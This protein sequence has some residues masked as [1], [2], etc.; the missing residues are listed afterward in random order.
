MQGT[1]LIPPI[2]L[3]SSLAPLPVT[4]SPLS[5]SITPVEPVI[6]S[7]MACLPTH[8][9]YASNS[10]CRSRDSFAAHRRKN[11]R[12]MFSLDCQVLRE[13]RLHFI[14]DCLSFVNASSALRHSSATISA[15]LDRCSVLTP[16]PFR[17]AST[18]LDRTLVIWWYPW[19]MPRSPPD[20]E[21]TRG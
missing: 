16:I 21:P 12:R 7:H 17:T 8:G 6:E 2:R 1:R 9:K 5:V 10:Y 19:K 3:N 13:E 4:P 14:L 15:H 18:A 20:L 11:K